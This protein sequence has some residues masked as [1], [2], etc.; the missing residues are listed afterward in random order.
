M[1]CP[2]CL[3]DTTVTNSAK[4]DDAIYRRRKCLSCSR[5]FTTK[6]MLTGESFPW[7]ARTGERTSCVRCGHSWTPRSTPREC[8]KCGNEN[9]EVEK[10]IRVRGM[11]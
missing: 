11:I 6:E 5:Q 7:A 2:S 9:F 10:R 4:S 3:R 8:P 1:I